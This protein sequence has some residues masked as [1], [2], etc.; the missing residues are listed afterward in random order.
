[1]VLTK[2][3]RS[4]LSTSGLMVP[5]LLLEPSAEHLTRRLRASTRFQNG[6]TMVPLPTRLRQRT[7][8]FFLS[9]LPTSETPSVRETTSWSCARPGSG[10]TTPTKSRS[11]PTPTSDTL[12]NRSSTKP[13][14]KSHGMALS[15]STLSSVLRTD[16]PSGLLVG[17]HLVT[18]DSRVLTTAPLVPTFAS[19]EPSLMITTRH[20][21]MQEL[22]FLEQMLK[23]CQDNGSTRLVLSRVLLSV[24]TSSCPD[25]SSTE[26]LRTTVSM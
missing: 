19:V 9:L 23:L 20:A 21:C 2:E 14:M 8:K 16:L 26:L 22:Q 11:L 7:L 6:T 13:L 3:A 5:A 17:L 24:T 1:M 4:S 10:K 25:T 15:R 12:P 18:P